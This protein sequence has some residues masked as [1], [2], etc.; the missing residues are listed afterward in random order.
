MKS[1][2]WFWF[3]CLPPYS[4][5]LNPI[6]EVVRN[7]KNIAERLMKERKHERKELT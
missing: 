4:P 7:A 2:A 5:D 6:D 1:R 3:I